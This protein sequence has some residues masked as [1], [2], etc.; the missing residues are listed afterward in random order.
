MVPE[1]HG[2][3]RDDDGYHRYQVSHGNHRSCHCD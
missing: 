2:I 1:D 3:Y